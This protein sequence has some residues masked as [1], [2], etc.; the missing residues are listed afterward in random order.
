M[1]FIKHGDNQPI[2]VVE[3]EDVDENTTKAQLEELKQ[4]TSLNK[5]SQKDKD[6]AK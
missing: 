4:N 2:Q 5:E 6:T 1:S 3:L